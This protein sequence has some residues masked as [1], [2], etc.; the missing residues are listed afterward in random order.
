M[1][2]LANNE[3][4]RTSDGDAAGSPLNSVLGRRTESAGSNGLF[5]SPDPERLASRIRGP[6]ITN[7][8]V[9]DCRPG[10]ATDG[11]PRI[12]RPDQSRCLANGSRAER[13]G[14]TLS[15]RRATKARR[16]ALPNNEMQRTKPAQATE[17]RR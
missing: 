10:P 6:R 9:T 14:R 17:L 13:L 2:E 16:T 5:P 12:L 4:Q 7:L 11:R 3:L 15:R 8:P 1:K